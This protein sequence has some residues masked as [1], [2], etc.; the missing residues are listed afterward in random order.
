MI[1]FILIIGC[2]TSQDLTTKVENTEHNNLGSKNVETH[3][4][5]S[6]A[7]HLHHLIK[8]VTFSR[9]AD[10]K[11]LSGKWHTSLPSGA[12]VQ[13]ASG[14]KTANPHFD[15]DIEQTQTG[16]ITET[17]TFSFSPEASTE[18]YAQGELFINLRV[19]ATTTA[20]EQ[21]L[22]SAQSNGGFRV[23]D[24]PDGKYSWAEGGISLP[25]CEGLTPP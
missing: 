4:I 8:R 7:P 17:G 25:P 23:A 12:T 5:D 9:S 22:L 3:S 24:S 19:W 18:P 1:L 2:F 6:F 16:Q 10:C 20:L 15:D 14:R 13:F 21:L 11:S